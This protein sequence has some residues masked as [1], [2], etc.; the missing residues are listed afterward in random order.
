[1]LLPVTERA[2]DIRAE[3]ATRMLHLLA[4]GRAQARAAER[5]S[6]RLIQK[7][8]IRVLGAEVVVRASTNKRLPPQSQ[9]PQL[10]KHSLH[11][12]LDDSKRKGGQVSRANLGMAAEAK[13]EEC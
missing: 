12:D 3:S 10:R 1:M 4:R 5:S 8:G 2:I 6:L 7:S 13:E 11:T 9:H